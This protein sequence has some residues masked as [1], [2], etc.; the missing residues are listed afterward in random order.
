VDEAVRWYSEAA[1]EAPNAPEALGDWFDALARAGRTE[2]AK[3]IAGEYLKRF[4]NG[5]DAPAARSVLGN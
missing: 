1:R 2:D 5:P 4:K 3:K